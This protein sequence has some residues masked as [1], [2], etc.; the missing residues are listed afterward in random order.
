M[1][2]L[3]LTPRLQAPADSVPLWMQG[4]FRRNCISFAD[5][6]SDTD[7]R[8]FWL[9]SESL[10]IDL[11]LPQLTQQLS[12]LPETMQQPASLLSCADYEGWYAHS[13]W[14][15]ER[16]SWHGGA[17]Y[18][19]HNRWPEPALLQRTGNCMVEFAPSGAY[20][21]DWRLMNALPGPLIGLELE[22]ECNL[23]TGKLIARKGALIICGEYAGLVLDRPQPAD[24]SAGKTLR[25]AIQNTALTAQQRAQMLEFETSVG[26]GNAEQ[27][28]RVI[29]TLQTSRYGEKLIDLNSFSAS[30]DA[31]YIVQRIDGENPVERRFRIDCWHPQMEF[32]QQTSCTDEAQQWL[33]K[34]RHT[35]SRYTRSLR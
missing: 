32:P 19:L 21:E 7:T 29:H 6:L 35:L 14:Q 31:G 5:G 1:H 3:E 4:A 33:Q 26:Y 34:E 18:Q 10:T 23:K 24:F 11:R 20:V 9:Q 16:L 22:S 8:V 30:E 25:E 12:V 17:C 15:S 27:G 13:Q 2:L 28:Y